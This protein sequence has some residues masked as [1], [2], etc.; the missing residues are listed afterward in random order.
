[1][2]VLM[3]HSTYEIAGFSLTVH[4]VTCAVLTELLPICEPMD[5]KVK[6]KILEVANDEELASAIS[7]SQNK[8]P[9]STGELLKLAAFGQGGSGDD[10]SIEESQMLIEFWSPCI[11]SI[12]KDGEQVDVKEFISAVMEVPKMLKSLA[13]IVYKEYQAATKVEEIKKI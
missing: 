5:R 1:M 13:S 10:F 6:A 7:K 11:D 9:L 8:E 3:D 12:S 4:G 2:L